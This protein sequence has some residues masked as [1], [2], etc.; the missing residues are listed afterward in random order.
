MTPKAKVIP[1][2]MVGAV[3]IFRSAAVIIVAGRTSSAR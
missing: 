3:S 1:A 2:Q